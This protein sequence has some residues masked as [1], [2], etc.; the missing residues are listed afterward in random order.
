ML[1]NKKLLLKQFSLPCWEMNESV[2]A[3]LSRENFYAIGGRTWMIFH[4]SEKMELILKQM[5][6]KKDLVLLKWGQAWLQHCW[7]WSFRS[8]WPVWNTRRGLQR[9][10]SL[11][12][13]QRLPLPARLPPSPS[14]RKISLQ[15]KTKSFL[16]TFGIMPVWE[17][18]KSFKSL[19]ARACAPYALHPSFRNFFSIFSWGKMRKKA[20][21]KGIGF[22]VP[23][24]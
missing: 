10:I 9:D 6:N 13:E 19:S 3:Y 2:T 24:W 23:R 11:L 20:K 22:H 4:P 7:I 18:I 1:V 8:G 12:F 17:K 14:L 5:I 21:E 16:F 15:L